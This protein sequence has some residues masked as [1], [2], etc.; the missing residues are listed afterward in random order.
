MSNHII[1]LQ[2]FAYTGMLLLAGYGV[3][4]AGDFIAYLIKKL[5]EADAPRPHAKAPPKKK[6]QHA[7]AA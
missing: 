2:L 7:G 3:A 6:R 1:V 4:Y 5:D